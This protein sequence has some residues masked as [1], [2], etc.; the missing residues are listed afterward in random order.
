MSCHHCGWEYCRTCQDT[1]MENCPQNPSVMHPAVPIQH[2]SCH[3]CRQRQQ[4]V[5]CDRCHLGVCE[6]CAMQ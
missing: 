5:M 6:D 4:D 3:V 1:H 2:L